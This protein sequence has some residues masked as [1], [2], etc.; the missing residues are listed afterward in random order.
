MLT[1]KHRQRTRY[2]AEY[3]PWALACGRQAKPLLPVYWEH[4]FEQ[5]ID[6]LRRELNITV[7]N[8]A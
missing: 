4:R 7:M 5:D 3:L 1:C 2:V 6:E 8:G